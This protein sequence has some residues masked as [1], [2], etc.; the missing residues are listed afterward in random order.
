[1]V[2]PPSVFKQQWLSESTS[3]TFQREGS[4]RPTKS[5]F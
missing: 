2:C 4:L 1:M 5:I 3:L